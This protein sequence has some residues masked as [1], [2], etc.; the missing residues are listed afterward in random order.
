MYPRESGYCGYRGY[1]AQ[2]TA[3]G[4]FHMRI[5][6]TDFSIIGAHIQR[7]FAPSV[8]SF[9]L[10]IHVFSLQTPRPPNFAEIHARGRRGRLESDHRDL[11]PPWGH[12]L[13]HGEAEKPTM[14]VWHGGQDL[15]HDGGSLQEGI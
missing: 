14:A 11:I 3:W 12:G 4:L 8:S 13:F 6:L 2:N 9:C 1:P 5:M 10:P 7:L 15:L